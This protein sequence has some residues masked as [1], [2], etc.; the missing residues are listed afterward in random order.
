[1]KIELFNVNEWA[2]IDDKQLLHLLNVTYNAFSLMVGK[3]LKKDIVVTNNKYPTP[4][5]DH[6]TNNK[7]PYKIDLTIPDGFDWCKIIFQFSHEICHAYCNF[8]DAQKHRQKWFE[9]VIC[10]A[11]SFSN[12]YNISKNWNLLKVKDGLPT[13]CH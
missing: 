7:E 8:N 13:W 11:A 3:D 1:M 5:I 2:G 12:L 6:F 10:D 9:E 4:Q